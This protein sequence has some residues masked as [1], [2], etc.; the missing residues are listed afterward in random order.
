M[1]RSLVP[2]LFA[3]PACALLLAATPAP[4]QIKTLPQLGS[5][6]PASLLTSDHEKRCRTSAD[7]EDPCTEIEIGDTIAW[8]ADTRA[9][10][11]LFT[12][13]RRLVTDNGLAVGNSL[14]LAE[15]SGP[16][17]ATIPYMK[18]MIDPKWKD[19][20]S[21]LGAAVWYAALHKAEYDHHFGDVVG[22][23]QSRYIQLK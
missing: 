2:T 19:T 15:P 11:Y 22:F 21:K 9:I 16:T 5:T 8:D 10:T 4:A 23:V 1:Q 6:I 14:R 20:D 17:D 7:H 13:D 12:D 3:L 18:W